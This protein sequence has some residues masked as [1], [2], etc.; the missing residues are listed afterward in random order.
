MEGSNERE[1]VGGSES[2][3]EAMKEGW[4][5]AKK[6]MMEGCNEDWREAMK[7]GGRQ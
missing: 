2:W 4:W 3:W 1:A 7:G 5:E 6:E